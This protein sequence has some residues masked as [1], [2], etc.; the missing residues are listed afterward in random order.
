MAAEA[1]TTSGW[2][3]SESRSASARVTV[4]C[5]AESTP[6]AQDRTAQT[7][8]DRNM[9]IRVSLDERGRLNEGDGPKVSISNA[10]DP[11]AD[12]KPRGRLPKPATR[13]AQPG[14][15]PKSWGVPRT[16]GPAPRRSR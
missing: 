16:A 13:K 9:G 5:W 8:R 14:H 11:P 1:R 2:T 4:R 7:D 6:A 3:H 10:I 15:T 12:G